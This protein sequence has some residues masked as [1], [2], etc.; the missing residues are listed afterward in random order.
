[1]MAAGVLSSQTQSSAY[2]PSRPPSSPPFSG[3]V[4]KN[5][6]IVASKSS[7]LGIQKAGLSLQPAPPF[8]PHAHTPL[9]TADVKQGPLP[10]FFF[11]S[12]S[13]LNPL[14]PRRSGLEAAAMSSSSYWAN[15]QAGNAEG[16]VK[17]GSE[18]ADAASWK[19]A[20]KSAHW[21]SRRRRPKQHLG[22]QCGGELSGAASGRGQSRSSLRE[23]LVSESQLAEQAGEG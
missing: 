15:W 16:K 4:H 7:F 18:K 22:R 12:P 1:M 9:F 14:S 20:W 17:A 3:E 13:S 10:P 2:A 11:L 23:G 21:H 8:S 5:L 6:V 19:A